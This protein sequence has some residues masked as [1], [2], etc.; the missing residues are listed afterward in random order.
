MIESVTRLMAENRYPE[1]GY[2]NLLWAAVLAKRCHNV[3]L[4][5]ACTL[6]CRLAPAISA[7]C[8][9]SSPTTA[10]KARRRRR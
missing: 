8:A 4:E 10:A 3:R 9:T 7:R 5:A 2:R 6:A 1:H